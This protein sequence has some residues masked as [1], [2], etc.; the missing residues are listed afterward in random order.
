VVYEINRVA[1]FGGFN[2]V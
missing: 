1:V 2:T